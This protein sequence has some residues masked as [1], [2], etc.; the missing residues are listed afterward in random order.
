VNN[1][2]GAHAGTRSPEALPEELV[3]LDI[4]VITALGVGSAG[5]FA[6]MLS[7]GYAGVPA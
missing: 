1:L 2:A 7:L 4:P 6:R 5:Q 3:D